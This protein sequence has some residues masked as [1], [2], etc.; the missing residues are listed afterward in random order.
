MRN[1]GRIIDAMITYFD[2]D[3]KRINHFLKVYAYAKAIGELEGLN[4]GTQEILETAAITHDIGIKNSE[5]KYNNSN[6]HYQQLEGPPEARELL[7]KLEIDDEIIDRVCWLIAHHHTYTDVKSM[8]YQI[9][10]EAD[11]LV[12]AFEDALGHD[13]IR[14]FRDKIFRTKSGTALL[15][16][17]Y[18]L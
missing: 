12:N 10:L 18:R 2:G 9:L 15:N 11:F 3:V 1:A 8:D 14:A 6:G 13:A 7:N 4:E 5:I 17:I 16:S